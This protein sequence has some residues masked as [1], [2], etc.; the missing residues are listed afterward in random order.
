M[1][2]A[3]WINKMG[4]GLFSGLGPTGTTQFI[5]LSSLTPP[6]EDECIKRVFGA[7][8]TPDYAQTLWRSLY[9]CLTWSSLN[10]KKGQDNCTPTLGPGPS[11]FYFLE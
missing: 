6:K 3:R 8:L 9:E 7:V 11:P 2:V 1:V 10:T 5:Q 4:E